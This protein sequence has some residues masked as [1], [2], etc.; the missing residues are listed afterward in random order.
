MLFQVVISMCVKL[1]LGIV[2][3]DWGRLQMVLLDRSEVRMIPLHVYFK[4]KFHFKLEFFQSGVYPGTLYPWISS[5]MRIS[6][7]AVFA[8]A[9]FDFALWEIKRAEG[10]L[11]DFQTISG[12]L[13]RMTNE[14]MRK[15]LCMVG[16]KE[17]GFL[18]GKFPSLRKSEFYRITSPWSAPPP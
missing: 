18:S 3:Q 14:K 1:I 16:A 17:T 8:P 9:V 15:N 4:F 5:R 7:R 6:C 13:S 2:S 12:R 11:V 10:L